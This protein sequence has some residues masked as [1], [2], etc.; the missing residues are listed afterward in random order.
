MYEIVICADTND[1]DYVHRIE[2]IESSEDLQRILR[3]IEVIDKC[4]AHHNWPRNEWDPVNAVEELYPDLSEDDIEWFSEMY[5]P[6]AEHG[7]HTIC[8]VEYYLVPEKI[9][10]L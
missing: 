3:I 5:L 10:L 9:R 6:G 2:K 1:A 8:S 7:I 4:K